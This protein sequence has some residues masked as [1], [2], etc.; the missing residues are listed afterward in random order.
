MFNVSVSVQI[1]KMCGC[2]RAVGSAFIAVCAGCQLQVCGNVQ[3]LGFILRECRVCYQH[4]DV[5]DC[6]LPF[7]R[8]N[9]VM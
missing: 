9:K 4:K 6:V 8:E 5:S 3:V 7:R 2:L 1:N